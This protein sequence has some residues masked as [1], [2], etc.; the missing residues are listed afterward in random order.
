MMSSFLCT[1]SVLRLLVGLAVC[2]AWWNVECRAAGN[3][4]DDH[5][6]QQEALAAGEGDAKSEQKT[7]D[8][9]TNVVPVFERKVSLTANEL[10]LSDALRELARQAGVELELDVVALSVANL[11]VYNTKINASFEGL[12][13]HEA[14]GHVIEWNEHPG[15]FRR[16]RGCKF[17]LTT[18]AA[19]RVRIRKTLPPWLKRLPNYRWGLRLTC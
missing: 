3:P 8:E 9:K 6:R 1:P 5:A 7:T 11:N 14:L 18:S 4:R 17:L 13:L 19:R 12:P 10:S 2:L 15:A 16:I